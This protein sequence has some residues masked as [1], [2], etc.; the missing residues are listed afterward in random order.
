MKVDNS[1]TVESCTLITETI[2]QGISVRTTNH[3]ELS[4][5]SAKIGS[6]WQ[7][8][9]QN[10]FNRL[11]PNSDLY[12]IYHNYESDALG[13]FDVTASWRVNDYQGDIEAI[14]NLETVVI[15]TGKY[16]IFSESGEMPGAVIN[17]WQAVWQYFNELDC[18]FDRRYDVDFEH[19]VNET[20]VDIYIGV[21]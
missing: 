12:G 1:M 18:R 14:D 6:L 19:Y 15:P 4:P 16:L 5:Q 2:C 20:K 13:A 11:K 9:Y 8:F 7:H 3:D 10:H 21:N 17:A